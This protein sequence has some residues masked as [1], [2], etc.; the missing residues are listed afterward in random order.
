MKAPSR[1]YVIL[2]RGMGE[3]GVMERLCRGHQGLCNLNRRRGEEG[4]M[5]RR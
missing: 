5:E 1:G 4:A 3:R 2:I